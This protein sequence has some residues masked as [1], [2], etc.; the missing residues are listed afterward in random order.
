[1]TTQHKYLQYKITLKYRSH[2]K[3]YKLTSNTKEIHITSYI[4]NKVKA[5]QDAFRDKNRKQWLDK[6][7]IM[8]TMS[9]IIFGKHY[10]G[11]CIYETFEKH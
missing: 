2:N 4:I 8:K 5:M 6:V 11:D 1:M 7:S 10:I 9:T 3:A